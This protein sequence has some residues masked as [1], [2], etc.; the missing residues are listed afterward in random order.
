MVM[1]T[2]KPVLHWLFCAKN[3]TVHRHRI[4]SSGRTEGI[5][6]SGNRDVMPDYTVE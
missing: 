6:S 1:T 2:V 4:V 5:V 3:S